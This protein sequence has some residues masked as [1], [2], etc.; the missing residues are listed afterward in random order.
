MADVGDVK[1]PKKEM[2]MPKLDLKW[3]VVLLLLV[4]SIGA[5]IY[6]WN[7]AQEAKSNSPEA[8]A[9]RNQE[10]S[11]QIV[12]NLSAILFIESES[13]PTVA[14]VEDPETLKAANPDF[15]S[16]AQTGD[17]LILYPQR[18]IIYRAEEN[19][20]INIAPIIDA[21]RLNSSQ[22]S[23]ANVPEGSFETEQ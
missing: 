7:D 11:T 18:A 10:E 5:A 4:V 12:S 8:V 21:S 16:N 6:F 1:K 3:V 22:E 2:K 13:D 20:I 9:A 14:R 15:Y 17:Y 23:E 19:K